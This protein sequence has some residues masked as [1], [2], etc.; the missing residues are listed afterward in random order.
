MSSDLI[1]AT[2]GKGRRDVVLYDP[3]DLI[4]ITDKDH[5]FYD[6]RA[7]SAPDDKL[8]S[9]I[10]AIGVIEP[11]IVRVLPGSRSGGDA[12]DVEVIAGRKRTIANREAN[13]RLVAAKEEP[14]NI[15]C[16]VRRG[17][18]LELFGVFVSENVHRVDNSPL[19]RA[20]LM[21]RMQALGATEEELRTTFGLTAPAVRYTLAINDCAP[22][23]K[24][25]VASGKIGA[26]LA[27]KEL[28]KLPLDEQPGALEKLLESG[29]TK[30]TA[31]KEA[32]REMRKNG[33]HAEKPV[34]ARM[35]SRLVLERFKKSLGKVESR[36]AKI[37]RAVVAYMLGSDRALAA[38]PKLVE[39]LS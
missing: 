32:V 36:E 29:V 30:G 2:N 17:T 39:A 1:A 33:K 11:V 19:E 26:V 7:E 3:E 34:K 16:I 38:Y 23:V 24:A 10:M 27:A 14:K 15:P 20:E 6:A 5:A 22:N 8:V 21:K 28:S 18:D 25:A 9:S 4:L 31:A 37:A 35:R 13:K 12:R